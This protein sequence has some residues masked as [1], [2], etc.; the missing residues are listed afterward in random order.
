[1]T[2]SNRRAASE[3][4]NAQP[5]RDG[6]GFRSLGDSGAWLSGCATSKPVNCA[7]ASMKR[8][9]R[10]KLDGDV[11]SIIR[12]LFISFR[13]QN[14]NYRCHL[15]YLR[16][17]FCGIE[18]SRAE[19]KTRVHRTTFGRSE[20]CD[21]GWLPHAAWIYHSSLSCC[22]LFSNAFI[23]LCLDSFLMIKGLL[24]MKNGIEICT[25]THAQV[26]YPNN[27]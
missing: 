6:R 24:M 16:M 12:A 9:Q 26:R 4:R 10:A 22:R 25:A 18:R 11:G 5:T 27:R 19:L 20:P 1:M 15:C 21:A 14:I 8:G 17:G 13:V 23:V 7:R 2:A 3:L